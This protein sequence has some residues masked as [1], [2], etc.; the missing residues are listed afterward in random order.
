MTQHLNKYLAASA[1]AILGLALVGCEQVA[2]AP[3]ANPAPVS[4]AQPAP[5]P[6]P[7]TSVEATTSSRTMEVKPADPADPSSPVVKKSVT[8]SSTTSRTQP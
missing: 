4:Q 7:S 3:A 8:D 1:F 6:A 5:T 2:P